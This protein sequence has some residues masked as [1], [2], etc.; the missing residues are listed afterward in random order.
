MS[1]VQ[2]IYT[3]QEG[4]DGDPFY[5]GRT[6]NLQERIAAH[7][8][9][10]DHDGTR[11]EKRIAE[12]QDRGGMVTIKLR[13]CGPAIDMMGKED[14]W[15]T[16]LR[17]Q[18]YE[19]LNS[20]SGDSDYAPMEAFFGGVHSEWEPSVFEKAEWKKGQPKSK[21]GEWSCWINGIQFFRQGNTKL[22]F[23]HAN[24][25]V[26]DVFAPGIDGKYKKACL[27]LTEGTDENK[28]MIQQHKQ[29]VRMKM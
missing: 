7:R 5:V 15:V 11:K 22:R 20:K 24:F 19:L 21:V 28:K 10:A 18:G 27:M 25:G 1:G 29:A 23:W 2:F 14:L 13:E 8:R 17:G 3:L 6:D 16:N 26:I 9:E 12:I 4:P